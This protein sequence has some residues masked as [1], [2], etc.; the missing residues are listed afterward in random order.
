M[1]F[2]LRC[3]CRHAL[4][5]LL[6]GHRYAL[7]YQSVFNNSEQTRAI[8]KMGFEAVILR[9]TEG[10]MQLQRCEKVFNIVA[11]KKK[12]KISVLSSY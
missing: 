11:K 2:V 1:K 5:V 10:Q 3:A 6:S 7:G 4:V 12:I 8:S 9:E